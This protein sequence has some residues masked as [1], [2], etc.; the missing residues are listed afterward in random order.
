MQVQAWKKGGCLT[1]SP[2]AVVSRWESRKAFVRAPWQAPP[3]V[4]ID[5]REAAVKK[6]SDL[7]AQQEIPLIIY[8]DGS[9]I[10]GR[11]GAAALVNYTGE[12]RQCQ[13]GTDEVSSV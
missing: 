3:K 8:T 9:G 7:Y 11:V 13:M 10:E 5:D 6:H 4:F 2:V 1:T 12:Y